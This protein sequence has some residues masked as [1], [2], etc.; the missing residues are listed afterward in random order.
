MF[1]EPKYGDVVYSKLLGKNLLCDGLKPV[2]WIDGT[3]WYKSSEIGFPE[4]C[5]PLVRDVHYQSALELA[6]RLLQVQ[7]QL[8][9][10]YVDLCS[11][12]DEP[13]YVAGYGDAVLGGAELLRQLTVEAAKN[14]SS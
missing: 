6:G 12:S 11:R 9:D 8:W 7:A 4:Q 5:E 13:S 3:R 1:T 2:T 14:A 10:R